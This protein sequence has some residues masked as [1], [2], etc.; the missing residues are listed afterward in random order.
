[1]HYLVTAN[2]PVDVLGA[3]SCVEVPPTRVSGR[4]T[5]S[6]QIRLLM[7]WELSLV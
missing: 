1:M 7:Y 3:A 5:L 2:K 4:I 6:Q